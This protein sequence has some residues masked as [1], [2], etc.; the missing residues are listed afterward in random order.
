MDESD[1]Q[2][3]TLLWILDRQNSD[4]ADIRGQLRRYLIVAL[5]IGATAGLSYFLSGLPSFLEASPDYLSQWGVLWQLGIMP[6]KSAS[7]FTGI[8]NRYGSTLITIGAVLLLSCL[9]GIY[10]VEKFE[11]CRPVDSIGGI[12]EADVSTVH[13][14]ID[15]NDDSLRQINSVR[16]IVLQTGEQGTKLLAGSVAF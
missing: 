4:Y 2:L 12:L 1:R 9:R 8:A 14:W 3:T 10:E 11:G 15:E 16:S 6:S 7:L 13:E 5:P